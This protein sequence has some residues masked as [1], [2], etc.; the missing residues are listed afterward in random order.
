MLKHLTNSILVWEK[1]NTRQQPMG[2]YII[3]CLLTHSD[4]Y[5]SSYDLTWHRET[6]S[7]KNTYIH[8]LPCKHAPMLLYMHPNSMFQL[9]AYT[10]NQQPSWDKNNNVNE[11]EYMQRYGHLPLP[12][13]WVTILKFVRSFLPISFEVSHHLA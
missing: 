2:E 8:T 3:N 4:S 13:T 9:I 10:N 7:Y 5:I 12:V 1:K 11:L 6:Y